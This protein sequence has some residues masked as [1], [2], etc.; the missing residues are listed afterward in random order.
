[1][2]KRDKVRPTNMLL[3][4]TSIDFSSAERSSM[5]AT[6]KKERE[7]KLS[8]VI[9]SLPVVEFLNYFFSP[10]AANGKIKHTIYLFAFLFLART[11]VI[12][13]QGTETSPVVPSLSGRHPMTVYELHVL[14]PAGPSSSLP[15]VLLQVWVAAP[16]RGA[17]HHAFTRIPG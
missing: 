17:L 6:Q 5:R 7:E 16:R 8:V 9:K 13:F 3:E 12:N 14:V 10:S 2:E 11:N 15:L 1:M 4:T